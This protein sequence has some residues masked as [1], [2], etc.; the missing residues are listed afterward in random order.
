MR[1][2]YAAI[3]KLI[4][5][6]Q[7]PPGTK[8]P[9]TRDLAKRL[10]LS[11]AAAVAAFEMLVAD[12]FAEARVGAGTFVAA[13]VPVVRT[14]T[15]ASVP[16][17][18][19]AQPLPCELGVATIDTKTMAVFRRLLSRSLA[20]PGAEHFHYSDARGGQ[21]LREAI[22]AYL[23]TARGVRCD[24]GQIVVTT[25]TMHGMNLVLR[26]VS[27]PGDTAWMEDPCY[28]MAKAVLE[29]VGV[30]IAGIPVDE[31]GLDPQ[32]GEALAPQA[33]LAYVTPSHQFPLG[34]PM[35]MR[36]RLA[37]LD[38]ARRRQTWIIEDDYD[39]EY[40]FAGPPLTAL[41]GMDGAERVVYLGTFSKV[42]FPGIRI[43]YA[44][45]PRSLLA[46]VLEFRAHIDRQPPTLAH[47]A[48]AEFLDGGHF[49]AHLRRA[50][51]RIE[52]ARDAL[53]S[54][55]TMHAGGA[56]SVS[57]PEQGLHLVARLGGNRDDSAIV[58]E[59]LVAGVGA[60]ALSPMYLALPPQQGLVLG[61]SG[62]GEADLTA[63]A[64]RICE[65]LR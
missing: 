54:A 3:R 61:F 46:R 65:V 10:G 5:N 57:A 47:A 17:V 19:P 15:A 40:R 49:A 30:R 51:R 23:T 13:Q 39:S 48:V 63:A 58:R 2:L 4:E 60:R 36:R 43:G 38:W 28:T 11:R 1:E 12:G 59:L 42:L 37:L 44:V 9:T 8:L 21:A 14:A 64:I 31:E 7:A 53:V 50:R 29:S 33:R 32:L 45:I 6:G 56:L 20:R 24:A 25:G 27:S 22:A 62:F 18:P 55:L 34:V 52:A 35:T 26:A 16:P 41:Q